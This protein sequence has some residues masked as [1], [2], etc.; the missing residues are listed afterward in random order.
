LFADLLFA[1][2]IS[3]GAPF[4][5]ATVIPLAVPVF[6]AMTVGPMLSWKRAA[7]RPRF[8]AI[9]VGS[10]GRPGRWGIRGVRRGVAAGYGLRRRG[11][12]VRRRGGRHR[13]AH[14]PVPESRWPTASLACAA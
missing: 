6:A 1:Q 12:D 2:K 4:F 11:L 3:V 5:D 9:V 8:A 13:G 10:P 14:P 7:L